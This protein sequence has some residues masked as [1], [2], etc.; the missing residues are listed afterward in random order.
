MHIVSCDCNNFGEYTDNIGKYYGYIDIDLYNFKKVLAIIPLG[1]TASNG[2][3]GYDGILNP[4]NSESAPNLHN[5]RWVLTVNQKI[6][7]TAFF[8]IIGS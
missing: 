2:D 5:A 3:N 7:Y 4:R 6:N 8:L 1:V